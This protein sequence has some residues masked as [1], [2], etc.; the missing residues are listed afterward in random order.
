VHP[1]LIALEVVLG[2]AVPV[3]WGVWELMSLRRDR[4]RQERTAGDTPQTE[5]FAPARSSQDDDPPT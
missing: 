3:G 1:P 2:F 5:S 4:R